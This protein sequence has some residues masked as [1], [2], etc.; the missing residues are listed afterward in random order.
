MEPMDAELAMT[1]A[2]GN[3]LKLQTQK[4]TA[5]WA[6]DQLLGRAFP[7]KEQELL[8]LEIALKR[9]ALG[10][11]DDTESYE[12]LLNKPQTML[13]PGRAITLGSVAVSSKQPLLKLGAS[14][15]LEGIKHG[16]AGRYLGAIGRI[17]R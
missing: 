1:K 11:P 13:D 8:A 6:G 15:F 9:R 10:L 5:T 4:E 12:D 2:L 7:G 16:P 17:F 14:P 3:Y